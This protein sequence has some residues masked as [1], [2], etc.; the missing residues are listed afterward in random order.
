[1]W[2][3]MSQ[4]LSLWLSTQLC[5]QTT[6]GWLYT[7]YTGDQS[8]PSH[9]AVSY[10]VKSA[11]IPRTEYNLLFHPLPPINKKKKKKKKK[12]RMRKV[13]RTGW[14]WSLLNGWM[15]GWILHPHPGGPSGGHSAGNPCSHSPSL[16]QERKGRGREVATCYLISSSQLNKIGCINHT[17][18]PLILTLPT[19]TPF[20]I[21]QDQ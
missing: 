1:M 12:K 10:V 11:I 20:F 8:I 3:G 19:L 6:S 7:T 9:P 5:P 16:Q 15:D 18:S 17:T 21:S 2:G 4:L 13:M 14:V